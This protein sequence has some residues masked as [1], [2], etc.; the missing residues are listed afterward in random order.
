M[1]SSDFERNLEKYAEVIVEVG[2]NLQPGQRLLI[3]GYR[4][5][6]PP[7]AI[8]L[9]RQIALKAYQVGARFVDAVYGDEQLNLIRFQ[10]APRA[11]FEEIQ[12]WFADA[13]L[14]YAQHGDALLSI[15]GHD[16]DLLADADPALL[17]TYQ[18]AFLQYS[19][20]V[21]ELTMSN[22]TTWMVGAVPTALWAAKVFPDVPAEQRVAKMWDAIFAMCRITQDDPVAAWH[23]HTKDL[24][25]RSDYLTNKRYIA[26]NYTAPGT[27]LTI[28]LPT[29]HIWHGGGGTSQKG[30][31][32]VANI[33]T[34]EVFTMPHKDKVD[35][36]VTATKPLSVSGTLIDNFRLTFEAGR[37]VNAVAEKGEVAL[38]R[39]LDTDEG[40]RH[41]GEAALVPD[42]SP[43]SQ[44]G[45]T[46]YNTLFDENASNHIALGT[47]YR[48]SMEGGKDLSAAE[49]AAAGGNQSL[50]H[51]DFMIGSGQMDVDGITESGTVEP[52][53]RDGNWAFDVA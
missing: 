5:P 25:L 50:I 39:L 53:M 26:L 7:E 20:P 40:A 9:V 29:G 17:A 14:D 18:K 38:H 22:A 3:H 30:I 46:F 28:G 15:I 10:H 47:A 11:S 16:P 19:K 27:N 6:A 21:Q 41:L 8:P 45:L 34:E 12:K 23:R 33:P 42:N 31:F 44:S 51:I 32:F 24:M 48:F 2:L 35:G 4:A 49:F 36:T 52:V 37:V 1:G 43:I 13:R